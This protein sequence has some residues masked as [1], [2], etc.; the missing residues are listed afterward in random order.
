MERCRSMRSRQPHFCTVIA[1]MFSC[2]LNHMFRAPL[3]RKQLASADPLGCPDR[4]NMQLMNSLFQTLEFFFVK[5]WGY[6]HCFEFRMTH[7][8]LHLPQLPKHIHHQSCY[9]LHHGHDFSSH[10]TTHHRGIFSSG[11]SPVS[12]LDIEH[13]WHV[14]GIYGSWR[15]RSQHESF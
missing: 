11:S 10:Q 8:C 9:P 6:H 15:V 14:Q 13:V 4:P 1:V 3:A 7:L 5:F 2:Q 12:L